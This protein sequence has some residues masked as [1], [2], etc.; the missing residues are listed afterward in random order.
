MRTT[1]KREHTESPDHWS[2]ST[3]RDANLAPATAFRLIATMSFANTAVVQPGSAVEWMAVPLEMDG[4][5]PGAMELA[6]AGIADPAAVFQM[7]NVAVPP[8]TAMFHA[9]IVH[10]Y[11]TVNTPYTAGP[12]VKAEDADGSPK[13]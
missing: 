2:H 4:N 3:T 5:A 1:Q 11:G 6:G 8:S 7:S 12:A 13:E 10:A 9:E